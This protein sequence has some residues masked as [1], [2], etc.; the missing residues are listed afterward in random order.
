M[1]VLAL[2]LMIMPAIVLLVACLNLADL[3]LARGQV[4]RQEMAIR[5]SLGGGRWRLT[6][7]LLTEGLLLAFAGGAAGLRALDMGDR[8]VAGVARSRVPRRPE[9]SRHS[10][11]T[12]ASLVAT[13]GFSL[14]ATLVFGAWPAWALT[15]RA[16]VDRSQAAGRR[17]GMA[18]AARHQDRQCAGH[19]PGGAVAP[20][21]RDRRTVPDER[22]RGRHRR[23]RLSPRRRRG[24]ADRSRAR[25]VQR[26]AGRR[27]A[28]RA[29]RSA[30]TR[31]PGVEAGRAS[32]RASPFSSTGE[33]RLVA[34]AGGTMRKRDRESTQSSSSSAA[35]TRAVARTS[36]CWRAG[37]QRCGI[38][39]RLVERGRDHGR[40]ARAAS[41]ARRRRARTL[42]Q[43]LDDEGRLRPA[44][45]CGWSASSPR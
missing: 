36:A 20:P 2:A 27:A 7:Q 45:R 10:I 32:D 24:R 13:V 33:S 26:G 12:G 21:A 44:S 17:G 37:F 29:R 11:S 16:V 34:A 15:G 42:I 18:A 31:S 19:R 8:G 4:R 9:P 43:F 25:R 5:S 41:L 35:T 38:G 23:S 14:A 3:L 1:A 30:A 39:A 6:R 22:D 40:C 28:A